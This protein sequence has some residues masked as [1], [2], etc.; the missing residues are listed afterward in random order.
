MSGHQNHDIPGAGELAYPGYSYNTT[1]NWPPYNNP[2]DINPL[3]PHPGYQPVTNR[4]HPVYQSHKPPSYRHQHIN[5]QPTQQHQS[6][7]SWPE[8]SLGYSQ[9]DEDR[10][11]TF[12]EDEDPIPLPL[13]P[14]RGAPVTRLLHWLV[15]YPS[16]AP[17]QPS[18]TVS[19]TNKGGR[20]HRPNC[21]S[22]EIQAAEAAQAL[23]RQEKSDKAAT[24]LA[25]SRVK[26][27][28]KA[29]RDMIK[30]K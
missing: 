10:S 7:V 8:T 26:A 20:T 15:P 17:P 18:T 13:L 23:K 25:K 6:Q 12:S 16:T 5:A 1:R 2:P 4:Y 28:Q 19:T 9:M 30:A 24:K 3:D 11:G 29:A 21:T 14:Q 27:A 22:E